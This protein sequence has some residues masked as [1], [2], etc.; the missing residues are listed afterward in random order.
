MVVVG[1]AG[2][3]KSRVVVLL[4]G[5]ILALVPAAPALGEDSS[6][7]TQAAVEAPGTDFNGDGYADLAIGVSRE[8][9]GTVTDAGGVNVIYGSPTGLSATA[10]PDQFWSRGSPNV[11]GDPGDLALLGESLAGADFNGDGFDDLAIGVPQD[12]VGSSRNAGAVNVIYG[13]LSGLSPTATPDQLWTQAGLVEGDPETDDVFGQSLAGG[14]FNGDGFADLA[15]GVRNE[16]VGGV[17]DAGAVDVIYGSSSGLSVTAIPDQSWS[18][19]SP[20][21]K[22]VAHTGDV[23]GFSLAAGNFGGTSHEDLA[24]GVPYEG[25]VVNSSGAVN[26]IYGSTSGLSTTGTPNQLWTQDGRGVEDTAETF[27]RFGWALA[28]ADFGGSPLADLAIGVP[29][30]GVTGDHQGAVSVIYGAPKGLSV[31]A[32]RD[33]IWSQ[34]SAGVQDLAEDGDEFG[35][36]LAAANFGG[37][38][39]ADLAIGVPF[40]S[41]AFDSQGGVN[42]IYGSPSGLS[43]TAT[44]D[45]FWSQDSPDVQEVGEGSD[46]FGWS[47]A[48]ANFGGTVRADLAIGVPDEDISLS[49]VGG[50]NVIYGAA[51]GL[52]ATATPDQFW[53]QGTAGVEEV[54]E[55]SDDMGSALGT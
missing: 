27:D 49:N 14:D 23:F 43:A 38:A 52:S 40:E 18:Q 12:D 5:G 21:V 26:V 33:Q 20:R 32:P 22:G 55:A 50:A 47:L 15:I 45:Q 9:V 29:G 11:E 39:Q 53:Y 34:D 36:S 25:E 16:D 24:I 37:S 46:W 3:M 10:T 51:G 7:P 41:E 1:G 54:P 31:T 42:V 19:D 44:P 4:V 35:R 17:V 48:A 28:A 2:V 8:D 6:E 13:S 30:E